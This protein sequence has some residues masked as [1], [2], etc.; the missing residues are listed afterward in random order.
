VGAGDIN[1]VLCRIFKGREV[2]KGP[3]RAKGLKLSVRPLD[4][5]HWEAELCLS[6]KPLSQLSLFTRL[7]FIQRCRVEDDII[8]DFEYLRSMYV[9]CTAHKAL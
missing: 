2:P 3:I 8:K 4:P 7:V 5:K 9:I 6:V 1:G